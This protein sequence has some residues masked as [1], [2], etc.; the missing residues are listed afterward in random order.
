MQANLESIGL[1]E[2][3][4]QHRGELTGFCQRMLGASE[5]EDSVQETFIRAWRSFER[6]EGRAP[7]RS[8]LY[9]IATNVCLDML[10][11]QKA[12][13]PAHRPRLRLRAERAGSGH[14]LRGH[15]AEA[16][17][18][19]SGGGRGKSG[20]HGTRPRIRL[21][22]T[23][24]HE[25]APAAEATC[26]GQHARPCA[27]KRRRLQSCSGRASPPSIAP[28]SGRGQRSGRGRLARQTHHELTA[29][30]WRNS[31]PVMPMPSSAPTWTRS[32]RCSTRPRPAP[33]HAECPPNVR[34]SVEAARLAKTTARRSARCSL[35]NGTLGLAEREAA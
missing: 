24:S 2:R 34:P 17:A 30:E 11:G 5:A 14:A 29:R 23:R 12:S 22:R 13:S 1:P 28:S 31:S 10:D 32:C 18:R 27:G 3:L 9:R 8:W 21:P 7:L 15:P 26:S 19:R 20:G 33:A 35:A 4:E 16:G 6:Y 25:P